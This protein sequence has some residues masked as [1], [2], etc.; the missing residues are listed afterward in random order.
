MSVAAAVRFLEATSASES[1]RAG[2]AEVIGVGDG[3]VGSVETLDQD[4]AQALLGERGV[5]VANFADQLGYHFTVAELAT[6]VDA[7]QRHQAGELSDADLSGL[8]GV[9]VPPP[10]MAAL[11]K[12]VGMV[13]FGI[14]Y[15]RAQSRASDR[16]PQVIQFVQKT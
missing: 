11:G 16:L 1:T 3:D 15:D 12:S 6:V 13:Y 14:R 7:F 8:L 2:L 4:E 5:M 9:S 10:Q